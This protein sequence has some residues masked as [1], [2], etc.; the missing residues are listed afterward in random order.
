MLFSFRPSTRTAR[1]TSPARGSSIQSRR[2]P[3]RKVRQPKKQ[4]TPWNGRDWYVSFGEDGNR[5]WADAQRYGFVSDELLAQLEN[6]DSIDKLEARIKP[7]DP[8]SELVARF[9]A[10]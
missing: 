8:P 2:A 7:K 9:K 5:S 4:Q 6:V 10:T 1:S 3:A